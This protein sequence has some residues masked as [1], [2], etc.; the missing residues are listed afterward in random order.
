MLT[1]IAIIGQN[2]YSNIKQPELD[3]GTIVN[4]FDYI[5]TKSSAFKEFQLIRKASLLKVRD[6]V[7]DS[8]KTIRKELASSSQSTPKLK[9]KI[10]DLEKE[11]AELKKE[12]LRVSESINDNINTINLFGIPINKSY[13]NLIVC[14]I[15]VLL[16]LLLI[17]IIIRFKNFQA[18]TNKTSKEIAQ[19]ESEFESYRKNSL[20]K[21]QEIMRKLQD[22]LNKNSH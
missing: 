5:L 15:I 21:E 6:H 19:L 16:L 14:S 3:S 18:K 17:I 22:E 11:V 9:S 4:Q 20:K 12:N 13:Y 2:E 10:N 8:L 1:S 7:L